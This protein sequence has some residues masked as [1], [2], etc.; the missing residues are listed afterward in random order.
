V[1]VAVAGE[2]DLGVVEV[3][4]AQP[5]IPMRSLISFTSRLVPATLE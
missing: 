5:S 2:L 3:K 4:A 1:S